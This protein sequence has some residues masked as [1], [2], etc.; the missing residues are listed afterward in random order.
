M[1]PTTTH[2]NV[3]ISAKRWSLCADNLIVLVNGQRG[4]LGTQVGTQQQHFRTPDKK[5]VTTTAY[6][7]FISTV[8]PIYKS[9]FPSVPLGR[10]PF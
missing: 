7:K 10:L 9:G 6:L 8:T 3:E 1:Y 2:T 5:P 4:G